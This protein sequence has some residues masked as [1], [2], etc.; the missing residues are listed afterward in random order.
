MMGVVEF[1]V[2]WGFGRKGFVD[3]WV[4]V[5]W[6]C[7]CEGGD[8]VGLVGEII[9]V[10]YGVFLVIG[11]EIFVVF[12]DEVVV[13]C[14]VCIV[15]SEEMDYVYGGFVLVDMYECGM[16]VDV[17]WEECFVGWWVVVEC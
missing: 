3:I 10:V 13:I 12:G 7:L 5:V 15:G 6:I 8:E 14:Y 4:Y 2:W 11:C 1:L 16:W 17:F 9:C